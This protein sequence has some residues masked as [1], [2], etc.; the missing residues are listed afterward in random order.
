[1]FV[2]KVINHITAYNDQKS[3]ERHCQADAQTSAKKMGKQIIQFSP[4]Q[5]DDVTTHLKWVG[6]VSV[7]AAKSNG[8]QLVI[9]TIKYTKTKSCK[10]CDFIVFNMKPIK[11]EIMQDIVTNVRRFKHNSPMVLYIEQV[12]MTNPR[13]MPSI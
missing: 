13:R 6:K 12:N 10:R 3:P 11:V 7:I 5:I 2:D 4:K 9:D 1:M 8:M